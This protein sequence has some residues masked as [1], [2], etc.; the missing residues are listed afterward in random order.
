MPPKPVPPQRAP[1]ACNRNFDVIHLQRLPEFSVMGPAGAR[2]CLRCGHETYNHDAIAPP[3]PAAVVAAAAP[4]QPAPAP[5]VA[6]AAVPAMGPMRALRV[7][8]YAPSGLSFMAHLQLWRAA[9]VCSDDSDAVKAAF[10][11]IESAWF[12]GAN[13]VA[14]FCVSSARDGPATF[15]TTFDWAP[16]PDPVI[17]DG[18]DP[19]R[20]AEILAAAAD[21]RIA[22]RRRR[23]RELLGQLATAR[24][25]LRLARAFARRRVVIDRAAKFF[26]IQPDRVSDEWH[27]VAM[28]EDELPVM[29]AQ[30]IELDAD[31]FRS[32]SSALWWFLAAASWPVSSLQNRLEKLVKE[33]G[34]HYRTANAATFVPLAVWQVKHS[35]EALARA[36]GKGAL[37]PVTPQKRQRGDRDED[38]NQ[39]TGAPK[40]KNRRQRREAQRLRRESAA[41]GAAADASAAGNSPS[42][43][44]NV[45]PST[46]SAVSRSTI[47]LTGP[48]TP[49]PPA[50]A[51]SGGRGGPRGGNRGGRGG[52][53]SGRF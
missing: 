35:P 37:P 32:I 46:G 38:E 11:A 30:D 22:L 9:R 39:P 25:V 44:S 34:A 4:A 24:A 17:P 16:I 49:S 47:G 13:E 42:T 41:A 53:R 2:I 1:A 15:S 21:E 3:A 18:V 19:A 28:A 48:A 8:Q 26:V 14:N 23:S 51:A 7:E 10:E 12:H 27:A 40:R 50:P 52:G 5:A 31:H 20:R 45:S 43:G 33:Y 29:T 36:K 6:P